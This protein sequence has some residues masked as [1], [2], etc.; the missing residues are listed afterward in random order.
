MGEVYNI[1]NGQPEK[2]WTVIATVLKGVNLSPEHRS[3]FLPLAMLVAQISAAIHTL[4]K[5]KTEP[6]LLPIKV[7]VAAYSMTLDISKAKSRLGYQPRQSTAE[8]LRE[9]CDWYLKQS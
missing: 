8:A 5:S 2:L 7:G 1:T 9:F 3:V 6:A 4:K